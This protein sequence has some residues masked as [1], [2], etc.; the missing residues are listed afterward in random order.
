[1][2]NFD[3]YKQGDPIKAGLPQYCEIYVQELDQFP[4][5]KYWRKTPLGLQAWGGEKKSF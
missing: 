4:T 2:N 1:M 5:A 3:S